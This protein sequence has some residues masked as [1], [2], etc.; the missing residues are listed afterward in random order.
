MRSAGGAMGDG[1]AWGLEGVLE[2]L[3]FKLT[4]LINQR[5]DIRAKGKEDTESFATSGLLTFHL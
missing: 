5:R 4:Q 3:A 2:K 1:M